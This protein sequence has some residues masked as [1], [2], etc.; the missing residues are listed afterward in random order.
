MNIKRRLDVMKPVEDANARSI[1]R[2]KKNDGKVQALLVDVYGTGRVKKVRV[3]PELDEYYQLLG[4][5]TIDMPLRWIGGK[6]FLI[7]CDDEAL[8]RSDCKPSAVNGREIMLYGNLL[9]MAYDGEENE[10]GLTDAE[11][12]HLC[13]HVRGLARMAEKGRI[14]VWAVLN[15]VTYRREG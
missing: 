9:V 1:A 3:K 4:C 10:R 2:W 15:D 12:D 5:T 11:V 13:K 7:V 8:F 14:D 6:L